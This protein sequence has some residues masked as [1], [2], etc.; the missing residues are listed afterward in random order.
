MGDALLCAFYCKLKKKQRLIALG[1]DFSPAKDQ[2]KK[3]ETQDVI[4]MTLTSTASG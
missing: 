2:L 4:V 3:I 1:S